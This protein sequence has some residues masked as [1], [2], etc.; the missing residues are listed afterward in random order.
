VS[1]GAP[2]IKA[3]LVGHM[4]HGLVLDVVQMRRIGVAWGD[5]SLALRDLALDRV[6]TSIDHEATEHR[7]VIDV[8][9]LNAYGRYLR[10]VSAPRTGL[11]NVF[12]QD[13]VENG[14]LKEKDKTFAVKAITQALAPI[15]EM[16]ELTDEVAST[17]AVFAIARANLLSSAIKG[18]SKSRILALDYSRW[19]ISGE[20]PTRLKSHPAFK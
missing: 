8:S 12:I 18:M 19:Q 15:S 5:L 6:S 11:H 3:D 14:A 2:R 20:L 10:I 9:W 13:Y 16:F 7:Q 1:A 4:V 17:V